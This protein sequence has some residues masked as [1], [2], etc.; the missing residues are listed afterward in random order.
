MCKK[1]ESKANQTNE[2][3]DSNHLGKTTNCGDEGQRGET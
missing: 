3:L 2:S 1:N